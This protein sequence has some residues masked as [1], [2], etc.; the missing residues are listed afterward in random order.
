LRFY[1]RKLENR[2]ITVEEK[3]ME[4]FSHSE[5]SVS[6]F[7]NDF[8]MELELLQVD[9]VYCDRGKRLLYFICPYPRNGKNVEAFS[10]KWRVSDLFA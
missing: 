6:V 8:S 4:G 5:V 7:W 1:L 3:P 9:H 2:G 10:Y